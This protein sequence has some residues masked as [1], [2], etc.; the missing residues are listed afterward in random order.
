[1]PPLVLWAMDKGRAN[2]RTA[3]VLPWT[4]LALALLSLVVLVLAYRVG[5]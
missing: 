1:M 3:V 2:E 4:M 5:V